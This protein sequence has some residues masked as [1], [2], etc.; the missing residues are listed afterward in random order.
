MPDI[1][2]K[3]TAQLGYSPFLDSALIQFDQQILL[4]TPHI[5]ALPLNEV[6]FTC[7][8]IHSVRHPAGQDNP[9]HQHDD[10]VEIQLCLDGEYAIEVAGQPPLTLHPGA[11]TVIMPGLRH[12]SR[13]IK[14][15]VRLT[16]RA[17]INGADA[18]QFTSELAKQA[19]GGLISF[20]E[21]GQD[22]V[23]CELFRVLLADTPN[24]WK[25]EIAGGLIR[26][27]LGTMLA[28][29]L[30]FGHRMRTA[31][32]AGIDIGNRGN[33][34]CE[35]ASTF[36]YAKLPTALGYRRDRPAYG[37]HHPPPLNRLFKKHV[38]TSVCHTLRDV[39]LSAAFRMLSGN[40]KSSIKEAAYRVG[41][42]SPSYFTQCFKQ[43]YG[44]LPTEVHL[45]LS[46]PLKD[47]LKYI[48]TSR[49]IAD[50]N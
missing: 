30:D 41:F 31:P 37:D 19:A 8:Y 35:R 36:I 15:G 5:L 45:R 39:R 50:N 44:I 9:D 47:A 48:D 46:K 43:Q 14:K 25:Y 3:L 2:E 40:P 28:T 21:R 7:Y 38:G 24:P 1:D 4:A 49:I 6:F 42:S 20:D 34:L 18:I 16:A 23:I 17:A 10:A 11:G 32:A 12:R 33:A 22:M 26:I 27:W 13:C 29:C